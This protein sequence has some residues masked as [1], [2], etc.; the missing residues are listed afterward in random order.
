MDG[1]AVCV[2][3]SNHDSGRR[4]VFCERERVGNPEP[5]GVDQRRRQ[6]AGGYYGKG[7][8]LTVDF[9]GKKTLLR[10]DFEV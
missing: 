2:S 10:P 1:H 6:M 7:R 8:L 5:G 4:R 3:G 9:W